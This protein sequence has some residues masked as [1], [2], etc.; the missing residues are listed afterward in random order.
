M[1]DR[2]I[3]QSNAGEV[4]IEAEVVNGATQFRT[5][6]KNTVQ[7]QLSLNGQP[8]FRCSSQGIANYYVTTVQRQIKAILTQEDIGHDVIQELVKDME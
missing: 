6:I 7:S 1:S 2:V 4:R 3:A 8:E 5:Y